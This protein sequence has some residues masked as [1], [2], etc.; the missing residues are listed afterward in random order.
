MT[1]I[2][3]I[4]A[5][6]IILFYVYACVVSKGYQSKK[7]AKRTKAIGSLVIVILLLLFGIS[8]MLFKTD[9]QTIAVVEVLGHPTEY[10]G[11]GL[12]TTWPFLNHIVRLDST[13]QGMPIGYEEGSNQSI[14][15]DSLMITADFNLVNIDFYATY[16]IV[17]GTEY[18]YGSTNPVGLL[19]NAIIASARNTIRRYEIDTVMTTGKSIIES[20]IRTD[21]QNELLTLH[22]GLELLSIQIQDAEAPTDEVK[23]AFMSVE[24]AR[25]TAEKRVNE[26]QAYENEKIPQAEAMATAT[27]KQAEANKVERINSATQ[28]VAKFN[29]LY[30]QYKQNPSTVKA[31]LFYETVAKIFPKMQIILGNDNVIVIK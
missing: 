15:D 25:Q 20:E 12:H 19:K 13:I 2:L 1:L 30:E 28:E 29:A 8:D 7:H 22:T 24:T 23:Q 16:R 26:A 17:D 11:S 3:S 27:I 5:A 4:A 10:Q 18:L 31:K 6:I 14:E 9:E 21:V